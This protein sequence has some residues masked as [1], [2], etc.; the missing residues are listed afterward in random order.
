MIHTEILTLSANDRKRMVYA[1]DKKRNYTIEAGLS[2]STARG[3]LQFNDNGVF[4]P[5]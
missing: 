5:I 3:V 1:T 2:G 4:S